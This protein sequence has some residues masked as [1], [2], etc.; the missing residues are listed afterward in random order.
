[1][2]KLAGNYN[3]KKLQ[4]VMNN[5]EA[6]SYHILTLMKVANHQKF[7]EKAKERVN[8]TIFKIQHNLF[9]KLPLISKSKKYFAT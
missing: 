9:L 8:K 6:M 3:I 4:Y 1:L 2:E 5:I 7:P